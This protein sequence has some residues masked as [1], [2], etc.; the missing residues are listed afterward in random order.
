MNIRERYQHFKEWQRQPFE[1]KENHDKHHCNNCHHDFTGLFCPDC[2]QKW[3]VDA[4]TW[5]S[6]R[7][8]IMD[9]WGMGSRSLPYTLWQLMLRP[10]YLIGEYI[11]GQRQASFPPVKMLV[12]VAVVIY[13]LEKLLGFKVFD[14]SGILDL[15]ID[16]T[17]SPINAAVSQLTSRYDWGS[18][19]IFLFMALPTFI[20]FRNSPRHT[21]HTLPQEFFIQVFSSVQFLCLMVVWSI[22][23]HVFGI[24][25]EEGDI[26]L[27]VL[28]PLII[29]YNYKQLFGYGFWQT[30]WRMVACW[31]LWFVLLGFVMMALP[32]IANLVTGK[33]SDG[34]NLFYILVLAAVFV[35]GVFFVNILN[36]Y[37]ASVQKRSKKWR[38]VNVMMLIFTA[39]CSVTF[40]IAIL[41]MM[42]SN[43]NYKTSTL[44]ISIILFLVSSAAFYVL[45]R[46]GKP[47]KTSK[48]A[49]DNNTGKDEKN[50]IRLQDT[51]GDSQIGR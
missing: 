14:E 8:G 39:L 37:H 16:G 1:Y 26:Q 6:I 34:S 18:L 3:N 50:E 12:I 42:T 48:H 21:R 35:V 38:L 22:V 5:K 46:R 33:P 49:E 20:V 30:L 19:V 41:G 15:S 23:R 36:N 11:S 27:F 17:D 7:Q 24:K 31:I 2:G 13:L 44:I 28:I 32:E 40:M 4:V 45:F 43:R 29:F 47:A 25:D 10:G 9:V 51:E